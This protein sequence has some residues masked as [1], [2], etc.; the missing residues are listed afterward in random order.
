MSRN[1]KEKTR[2][3]TS[4]ELSEQMKGLIVLS[5]IL[6]LLLKKWFLS[7]GTLL[8][9][10]RN[11]DFIPWDWD[12]E[13][14]ILTEE[15]F[16]K[17]NELLNILVSKGFL[18]S[19]YN[20]SIENF[21]IVAQG[22]GTEYEIL[23]RYLNEE[24]RTRNRISTKI[25]AKFF[26]KSEKV[27]LRG[28]D[29]PAPSPI[30]NFLVA[31][32]GDWKTPKKSAIKK[33]YFSKEAFIKK[34]KSFIFELKKKFKF[35]F[36]PKNTQEFPIFEKKDLSYFE[37]WD[38]DLGWCN[39]PNLTRV[40]RSD[41][42]INF[43]KKYGSVVYNTDEKSSR[44]CSFPSKTTE[45]SFYGDSYCMC[46]NVNDN[47]TFAWHLGKIGET[48][49]SNYGV[50]NYGLDQSLLLLKRNYQN[51]PSKK[52]VIAVSTSTLANCCSIYGHYLNNGNFF[53]VKPHF[54]F[55]SNENKLELIENPINVKEDLLDLKKY[56][57]FFQKYDYHYIY[58]HKNRLKHYLN[59]LDSKIRSRVGT[60]FSKKFDDK[61]N[62]KLSFWDSHDFLFFG[63][64][65]IYEQLSIKY[66][67]EGFFLLQ[68]NKNDLEK[69]I[70]KSY[71]EFA[72]RSTINK[73]KKMFPKIKFIDESKIFN[74]N[75]NVD[76]LYNGSFHSP[77]ANNL[78]AKFL[79]NY[80]L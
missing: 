78:I 9:A 54:K 41:F 18:I 47:D 23:G 43:K 66:G 48:R 60:K 64:L 34:D 5:D 8:G 16:H 4:F 51:D 39:R 2:I 63:L 44:I 30:E 45:I 49:I 21:K 20:F 67:F 3:R 28:Y 25:P 13:V 22:W 19:S 71:E 55:N 70:N 36:L 59:N 31:L 65:E 6:N 40:D 24:D 79:S 76:D 61:T 62:Y 53:A 37:T 17:K 77:L 11:G 58:W 57:E 68:H 32:Y 56:K 73:A 74:S 75:K 10:F 14:T 29:F 27:K 42:S 15:A 52:V 46:R 7:G 35:F 50:D 1:K 69:I 38:K 12:I 33:N 72:W 26:E 80:L